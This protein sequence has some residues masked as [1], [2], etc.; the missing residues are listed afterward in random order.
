QDIY[1]YATDSYGSK[2][3]NLAQIYVVDSGTST[4]SS[5]TPLFTVTNGKVATNNLT[6]KGDYVVLSGVTNNG[7]VATV[8]IVKNY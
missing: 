8:K 5:A 2:G 7:L 4:G 3:L 6:N 1:F